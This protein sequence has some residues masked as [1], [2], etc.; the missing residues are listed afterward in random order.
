MRILFYTVVAGLLL[1]TSCG[2]FSNDNSSSVPVATVGES[3]LYEED[4]ADI[5]KTADT[6]D[7]SIKLRKSYIDNW[8]K[9]EVLFQHALTYLTDS[10]KNKE[11]ELEQYYRSLI[12]YEYERKLVSQ[13]LDTSVSEANIRSYY[14]EYKA[15]FELRRDVARMN[16]IEV[17]AD[18]PKLDQVQNWMEESGAEYRDSVHKYCLVYASRFQINPNRWYYFT[19]ELSKLGLEGK[20][21]S[22]NKSVGLYY[23]AD[24]SKKVLLKIL[25]TKQAGRIKPLGM[26]ADQ[27]RNILKNKK[28]VEFIEAKQREELK[29]ALKN[30]EYQI[31]E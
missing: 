19:Y 23:T 28:K 6:P 2:R 7:D 11:H 3:V 27:I 18:V 5:F 16:Y 22:A 29:S 25:E 21:D 9:E 26:V 31:Y 20:V 24:S 15:S 14:Q 8:I 13:K 1:L 4:F 30:N 17:N 12:R 10:Q